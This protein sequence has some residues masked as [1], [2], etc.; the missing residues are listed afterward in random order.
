MCVCVWVCYGGWLL[1]VCVFGMCVCVFVGVC[2]CVFLCALVY[3]HV[4]TDTPADVRS[5]ECIHASIFTYLQNPMWG[6]TR[7]AHVD[8]KQ[9]TC[10]QLVATPRLV[11]WF[12][13]RRCTEGCAVEGGSCDVYRVNVLAG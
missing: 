10:S 8:A 4:P 11:E 7:T 13:G 5:R 1:V 6:K 2:M 9:L 3:T 12:G